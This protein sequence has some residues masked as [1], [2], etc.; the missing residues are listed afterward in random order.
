ML[1]SLLVFRIRKFLEMAK[2][3]QRY[4]AALDRDEAHILAA[5][6]EGAADIDAGDF[7]LIDGP[8]AMQRLTA[9]L[10]VSRRGGA[11]SS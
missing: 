8:E 4:V 2:W 11:E 5:A 6:D 7:T 10:R 1:K 3:V 9:E